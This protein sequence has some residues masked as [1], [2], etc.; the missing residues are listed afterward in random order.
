MFS[1]ATVTNMIISILTRRQLPPPF[2]DNKSYPVNYSSKIK[3]HFTEMVWGKEKDEREK[4]EGI[5][6]GGEHYGVMETG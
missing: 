6:E 1:N 5:A 2:R 4:F 3:D